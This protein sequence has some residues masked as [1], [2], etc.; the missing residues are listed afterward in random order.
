MLINSINTF[1]STVWVPKC[2]SIILCQFE[3]HRSNALPKMTQSGK[4]GTFRGIFSKVSKLIT[5]CSKW[6]KYTPPCVMD[7]WTHIYANRT[8]YGKH[9]IFQG[10]IPRNFFESLKTDSILFQIFKIYPSMSWRIFGKII[11]L[12]GRNLEN[13]EYLTE[14]CGNCS[15]CLQPIS[16][17]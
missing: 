1:Y 7:L 9:G 13:T 10:N 8:Q 15:K 12:V 5:N 6:S 2:S 4:H 3:D 14:C 17:S 11:K 16:N